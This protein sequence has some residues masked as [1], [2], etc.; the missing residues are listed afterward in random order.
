MRLYNPQPS[1]FAQIIECDAEALCD[2]L[3]LFECDERP[4][5]DVGEVARDLAFLPLVP[6]GPAKEVVVALRPVRSAN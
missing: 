1:D 4:G 5:A 2:L 3:G 6:L